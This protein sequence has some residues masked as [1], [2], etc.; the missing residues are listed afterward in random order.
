MRAE[1]SNGSVELLNDRIVIR[2]KG[3]LNVLTQGFQGE[4]SIPYTSITAVQFRPA[5][6][7]MAGVIQF[8]MKGGREFYGGMLEATQDE[9]AIMFTRQQEKT[10]QRVRDHVERAITPAQGN[11]GGNVGDELAALAGLVE[12]GFLTREE[13]DDRKR[14]LLR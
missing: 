12:K 9:N 1:G 3:L 7:I 2:R 5:G 14:A 13:F 4:K 6:S 11:A 8:T 10:F